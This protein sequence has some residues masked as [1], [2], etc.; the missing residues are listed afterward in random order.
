MAAAYS[1]LANGGIYMR[2]YI[3]DSIS[4]PDGRFV[5][6]FPEKVRRVI[7]EETSKTITA[8]LVDGVRNG[9]A[10]K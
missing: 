9:F 5:Q 6:M 3:V 10:K 2:P 7:S 1:A 8:M 4:Y